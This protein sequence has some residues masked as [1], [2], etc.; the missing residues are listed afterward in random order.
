MLLER[1]ELLAREGVEAAMLEMMTDRGVPLLAAVPGVRSVTLGR[2]VENSDKLMLLVGWEHLAAHEAFSQ[3]PESAAFR[4]LITPLSRGG[5]M[6]H[7]EMNETV[8]I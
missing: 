7:F 8:T 1:A 5:A 2:G 4:A 6:E 3:S